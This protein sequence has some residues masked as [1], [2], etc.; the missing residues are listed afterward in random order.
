[1]DL[2]E[3]NE[4]TIQKQQKEK[5]LDNIKQTEQN[6]SIKIDDKKDLNNI[7]E[8]KEISEP[9]TKPLELKKI[10]KNFWNGK[11]KG[12]C[13]LNEYWLT[14]IIIP[15]LAIIL[16]L[17]AFLL[18]FMFRYVLNKSS[19]ILPDEIA[20]FIVFSFFVLLI[21]PLYFV[22]K[23]TI[24]LI[25]RRLNDIGMPIIIQILLIPIDYFIGFVA[26]G[27]VEKNEFGKPRNN[28][29]DIEM[30]FRNIFGKKKTME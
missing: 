22:L 11:F 24:A 29:I 27:E 5:L 28:H 14:N 25:H 9:I 30:M 13:S 16:E 12:R 10:M 6:E 21:L 19:I 2:M 23:P 1:M 4:S 18:V 20:T 15:F 26:P 8:A 7:T 3:H 17:F